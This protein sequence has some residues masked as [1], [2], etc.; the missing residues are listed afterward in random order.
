MNLSTFIKPVFIIAAMLMAMPVLQAQEE[1][2]YEDGTVWN[3]TIVRTHANSS[4]EYLKG[5]SKTWASSMEEMKKEGIIESY[6]ILVGN[7]SNEDDFNILL[8]IE[9]KNM[10]AMDPD[11]ERE[12]K[13]DAVQAKLRE[14]L[15]DEYDKIV[16]NYD[17]IRDIQGVKTMRELHLKK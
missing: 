15:G 5:I 16:K 12:K 6:K 8:M 9:V 7:A 10:A 17:E 1:D 14:S 13:M 3:I 11:P 4:G 2:S